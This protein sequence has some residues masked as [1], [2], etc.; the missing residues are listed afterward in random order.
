M[1]GFENGRDVAVAE[2]D[3]EQGAIERPRPGD[4]AGFLDAIERADHLPIGFRDDVA[5]VDADNGI[6]LDNENPQSRKQ[7]HR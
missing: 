5:K 3:V 2:V 4:L 1:Q 6:V 7:S